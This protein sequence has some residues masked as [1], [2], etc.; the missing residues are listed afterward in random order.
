[1]TEQDIMEE[2]SKGYLE[3]IAN[4]SG[5]FNSCGRDYGTDLTIR[6]ARVCPTRKRYLTQGKAI[7]IQIKATL[8]HNVRH[9]TDSSKPFIKFDLESKNYNDLVERSRENGA[10]IPLYLVV[11]ILPQERETWLKLTSEEL[12]IKKCAYWYQIQSDAEL[13]SNTSTVTI[14]VPKT[15]IVC[16]NFYDT[17]FTQL[18]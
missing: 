9:L 13:S 5:Y 2:L 17:L 7:D 12:V 18:N 6:K 10:F 16:T 8:E 1:M 3:M 14:A 4:R 15:N 11:F